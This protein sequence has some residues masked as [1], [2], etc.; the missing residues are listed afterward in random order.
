MDVRRWYVCLPQRAISVLPVL[1]GSSKYILKTRKVVLG[2]TDKDERM[3][4]LNETRA[5]VSVWQMGLMI[6]IVAVNSD[7]TL[8]DDVLVRVNVLCEIDNLE[9][10]C[11]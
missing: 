1:K 11:F 3:G 2:D 9:S 8:V 6:Q 5:I 7:K 4:F 10:L